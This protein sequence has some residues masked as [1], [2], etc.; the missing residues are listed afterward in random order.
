MLV[1]SSQ[2]IY[3]QTIHGKITDKKTKEPLIGV[4]V[5]LSNTNGTTTDVDGRFKLV[6]DGGENK[7]TFKYVFNC[8]NTILTYI[9]L[10]EINHFI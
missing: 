10:I 1:I 9:T 4:N 2:T 6:R 5:I 8:S 3:S 7:I